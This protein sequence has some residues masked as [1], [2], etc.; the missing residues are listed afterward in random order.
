[1]VLLRCNAP[2]A[3]KRTVLQ[4]ATAEKYTLAFTNREKMRNALIGRGGGDVVDRLLLAIQLLF[5]FGVGNFHL[6]AA[7]YGVELDAA[8]DI[9]Q[10]MTGLVAM[11]IVSKYHKP[12]M[13]GR[14]NSNNDVQGSTRNDGN[15]EGLPSFKKFLEDS[16]LINFVAGHDNANGFSIAEKNIN[17]L[18]DYA[19]NNLCAADFENC[20]LVDYVLDAKND[21]E[22]LLF[23]LASHPEYFGNHIDEIKFVVKNIELASIMV[24]GANKDSVKINYNGIDYVKFKD[25]DFIEDIQNNRSKLLNVY[26]RANVNSWMGKKSIQILI[27]DYELV[28]DLHKYDF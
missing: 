24:M 1:V 14:R 23:S 4:I 22:E 11:Q 7:R 21:N 13:L 9:P 8:D 20:Y 6:S 28:E 17:R 26:G 3:V 19:N 18:I 25:T 27:S 5:K 10:E 12:V 2:R 15:F 16:N